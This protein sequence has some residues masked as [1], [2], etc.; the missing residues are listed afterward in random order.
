M[1]RTLIIGASS[2]LGRAIS[3]SLTADG[4]DVV[5]ASLSGRGGARVIDVTDTD[6]ATNLVRAVRPTV[7]IYL[8]RPLLPPLPEDPEPVIASAVDALHR[9]AVHGHAEGIRR[10]LFASSAAVY[11]VA[12]TTARDESDPTPAPGAYAQLKLRSEQAL[13]D[14]S[15]ATGLSALSLRIFNVYGPGFSGSLVNRLQSAADGPV[16][17]VHATNQFVRDYVHAD[18]VAAV[19]AAAAPERSPMVGTVNVGTGVGIGNLD[20]LALFPHA[21]WEPGAPL[22]SPSISVAATSRLREWGV[23]PP[24]RLAD[25]RQDH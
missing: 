24:A 2:P 12:N 7:V 9:F 22:D 4:H 10:L 1:T 6:S 17:T 21:R 8:A 3:T 20:L 14:A 5:G 19:F 15:I 25:T 13:V 16:P 18:D 11:G 23:V